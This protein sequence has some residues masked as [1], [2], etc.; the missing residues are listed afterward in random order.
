MLAEKKKQK[1][2]NAKSKKGKKY[3]TSY[4][5]KKPLES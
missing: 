2:L 5:N 1:E 4:Q 3:Y